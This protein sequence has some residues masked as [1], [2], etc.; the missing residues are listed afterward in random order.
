MAKIEKAL[1]YFDVLLLYKSQYDMDFISYIAEQRI[2]EAIEK[3]EFEH[4]EGFGKPIDNSE[5]FSIPAEERVS[6]HILKNAGVIP[7]EV[8]LR[9]RAYEISQQIN[10]ARS[11]KDLPDLERKRNLLETQIRLL[12]ESRLRK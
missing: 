1:L 4:L 11:S 10:Q 5:Y 7:E 12:A 3:G 8:E 9:K 2:R 6:Y